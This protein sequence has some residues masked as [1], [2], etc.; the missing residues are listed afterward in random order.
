MKAKEILVIIQRF[1]LKL[2]IRLRVDRLKHSVELS[3]TKKTVREDKRIE[4]KTVC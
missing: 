2:W 1:N 4:K 3:R